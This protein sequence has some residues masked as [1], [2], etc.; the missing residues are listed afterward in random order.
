MSLTNYGCLSGK[1]V[2]FI[3]NMNNNYFSLMRYFRDIGV[4]AHLLVYSNEITGCL[5]HFSPWCDTWHYEAW[6]PYIHILPFRNDISSVVGLPK[7]LVLPPSKKE[8]LKAFEGYDYYIGTGI[9]PALF[10]KC[11]LSLNIFSPY[12]I[13][14]EYLGSTAYN[15]DIR[16]SSYFRKILRKKVKKHQGRGIA[17]SK[18]CLNAGVLQTKRALLELN[19]ELFPLPMP[20]V[21]CEKRIGDAFENNFSSVIEKINNHKFTIFHHSRIMWKKPYKYTHSEWS[22]CS[23]NTDYL[24]EGFIRF[25]KENKMQDAL[26]ILCEY[27]P[28]VEGAKALLAKAGVENSVIW[29]PK[30]QRKEVLALLRFVDVG[31][32]AFM[33]LSGLLWGGAGWEV[34]ASSKP[35]LQSFNLSYQDFVD[36][37]GYPPPPLLDVKSSFDVYKH[38]SN[39]SAK[40]AFREK[41]G[42]Q[43]QAW[44]MKHNG[45]NLA[46]KWLEMLVE[47]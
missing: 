29:L 23:K 14:I 22:V 8:L 17:S 6:S 19:K 21:Y 33:R 41:L 16:S 46:K 28:D 42:M 43:M 44:F 34:M 40:K 37:F 12:E 15:N 3:G 5:K 7:K 24:L 18:L 25:K 20:M 30:L 4:D 2:A 38:L 10:D 11:G 39:L 13:G 36:R 32:G 27:G 26:L 35:L 1:K 45:E 31:C 47:T 9:T